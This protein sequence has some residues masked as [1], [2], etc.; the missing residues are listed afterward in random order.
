MTRSHAALALVVATPVALY[1]AF[2]TPA[3]AHP[4]H[5]A[6]DFLPDALGTEWVY[7]G[8]STSPLRGVREHD[9]IEVVL[10]AREERGARIVKVQ[11]VEGDG[12]PFPIGEWHASKQGL[13]E[14]RLEWDNQPGAWRT[15]LPAH[16][17]PGVEWTN[18]YP[19]DHCRAFATIRGW[20]TI[21]LSSGAYQVLRVDF[22]VQY[23]RG[24]F[25]DSTGSAWYAPGIGLVK[26]T[27]ECK[28]PQHDFTREL[29]SFKPGNGV[30]PAPV[31][32]QRVRPRP[33]PGGPR[34]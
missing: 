4:I 14:R 19:G 24:E 7:H 31:E 5:T 15:I 9:E 34:L 6:G 30:A 20:E 29:T 11:Q 33:N 26:M 32:R 18:D 28:F 21:R 2:A 22:V 17:Q 1:A 10:A 23:A 3:V 8:T 25:G 16:L 12:H 13:L 27:S